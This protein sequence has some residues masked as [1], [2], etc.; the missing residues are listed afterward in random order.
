[1]KKLASSVKNMLSRIPANC[2]IAGEGIPT[3]GAFGDILP[4]MVH[5]M[6]R[7]YLKST[8]AYPPSGPPVERPRLRGPDLEQPGGMP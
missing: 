2:R 6:I 1:M 5:A 3:L 4:K 8:P 7:K